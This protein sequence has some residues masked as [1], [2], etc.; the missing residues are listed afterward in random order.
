MRVE[1]ACQFE[2]SGIADGVIADPFVPRVVMTVNENQALR[3]L[4]ALDVGHDYG[5]GEPTFAQPCDDRGFCQPR[6]Y[7]R[8]ESLAVRPVDGNEG[9]P[10]LSG[11]SVEVGRAPDG[12][13]DTRMK[14]L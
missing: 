4:P 13:A 7:A 11:G 6:L 5:A 8:L 3:P 10:W 12:R 14:V 2:K 9:Y 1:N